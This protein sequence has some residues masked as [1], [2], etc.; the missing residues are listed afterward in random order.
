MLIH[1]GNADVVGVEVRDE[2]G[3]TGERS[4]QRVFRHGHVTLPPAGALLVHLRDDVGNASYIVVAGETASE[5]HA[6]IFSVLHQYDGT[7]RARCVEVLQLAVLLRAHC[8]ICKHA[9]I[10]EVYK[11]IIS[12]HIVFNNKRTIRPL[13]VLYTG[14]HPKKVSHYHESSLNRIKT[15]Q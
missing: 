8:D 10:L 3:G 6:S 14:W 5:I 1:T 9:N 2:V 4:E 12:N 7:V 13:K 15:R 11:Q